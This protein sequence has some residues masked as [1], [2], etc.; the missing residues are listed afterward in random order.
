MGEAH[1]RHLQEEA[2][3]RVDAGVCDKGLQRDGDGEPH[4]GN[5]QQL[6]PRPSLLQDCR[7]PEV[8]SPDTL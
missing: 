1:N 7:R 3:P 6:V 2:G 4:S 8:S 5:A